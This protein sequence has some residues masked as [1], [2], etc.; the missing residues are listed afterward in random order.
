MGPA[1]LSASPPRKFFRKRGAGEKPLLSRR[2]VSP[3]SPFPSPSHLHPIHPF[4]HPS[5]LPI[6]H[7]SAL[8][9]ISGLQLIEAGRLLRDGTQ[10][11]VCLVAVFLEVGL[12]V[13]VGVGVG[14]GGGR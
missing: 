12:A 11:G 4:F 7:P 14:V 13:A 3:E 1:P 10:R 5:T 9:P 8:P 6:I 2:G